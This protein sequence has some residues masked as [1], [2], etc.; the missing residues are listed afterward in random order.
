MECFRVCKSTWEFQKYKVWSVDAT[1]QMGKN[2]K[3]WKKMSG[4]DDL[5]AKRIEKLNDSEKKSC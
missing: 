5:A 2:F 1:S 4:T 3:K